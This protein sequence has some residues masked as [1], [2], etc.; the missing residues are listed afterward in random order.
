MSH[1]AAILLTLILRY[2]LAAENHRRDMLKAE[3]ERTGVGAEDFEDFQ[4]V[5]I[6]KDG[7]VI[8]ERVDK[9]FLDLTDR[10]NLAFRYVL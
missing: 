6:M 4:V 8:R 1:L 3:A 2:Q 10:E 5:E 9:T 7:K